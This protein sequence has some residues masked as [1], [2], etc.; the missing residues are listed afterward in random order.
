MDV[1]SFSLTLPPP[2]ELVLPGWLVDMPSAP[3]HV[4]RKHRDN[5][6]GSPQSGMN[7]HHWQDAD[8][9]VIPKEN[10][11]LARQQSR[12]SMVSF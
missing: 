12:Q 2:G 8:H 1:V 7:V 9:P 10:L 6:Y 3:L 11:P 5:V 4:Q